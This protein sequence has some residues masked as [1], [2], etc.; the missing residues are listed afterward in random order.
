MM[1]T[2]N[3][4]RALAGDPVITRAGEPVEQLHKFDT[5]END[6]IFGV[7]EGEVYSWRIGGEF[8]KEGES[9]KDL[10]MVIKKH[11]GWINIYRGNDGYRLDPMIYSSPR[12]AMEKTPFLVDSTIKIGWEE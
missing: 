8:Y 2:F 11:R 5:I 6:C 12:S 4:E 10:F 9:D 1:K 7:V 3:L